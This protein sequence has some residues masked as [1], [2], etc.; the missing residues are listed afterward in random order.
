MTGGPGYTSTSPL[1]LAFRTEQKMY[2]PLRKPLLMYGSS[3]K[4]GSRI[5]DST[6]TPIDI[7]ES[8]R[9]HTV[10]TLALHLR[11]ASHDVDVFLHLTVSVCSYFLQQNAAIRYGTVKGVKTN[12]KVLT[13]NM[14]NQIHI[15][16]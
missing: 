14:L 6:S 12:L 8:G 10:D 3:Y 5:D 15:T 13:Y 4:Y 1:E 11:R 7:L 16:P 2:L 9:N